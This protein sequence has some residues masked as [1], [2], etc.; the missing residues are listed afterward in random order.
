MLDL[1]RLAEKRAKTLNQKEDQW[2]T[3]VWSSEFQKISASMSDGEVETL[4]DL[5][6]SV[7]H[8]QKIVQYLDQNSEKKGISPFTLL[9]QEA[10]HAGLKPADWIQQQVGRD[11]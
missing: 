4:V 11:S 1:D 9:T 8:L 6:P 10:E 7:P 2:K 5:C 3:A